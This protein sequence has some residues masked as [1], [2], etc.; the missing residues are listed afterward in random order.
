MPDPPKPPQSATGRPN[1]R[2][3]RSVKRPGDRERS[4]KSFEMACR[5]I[6]RQAI[7]NSATCGPDGGPVT[8]GAF[9]LLV[10]NSESPAN[11]FLDASARIPPGKIGARFVERVAL[12]GKI[13]EALGEQ[14]GGQIAVPHPCGHWWAFLSTGEMSRFCCTTCDLKIALV[15][16]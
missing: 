12:S 2:A 8:T 14:I 1:R 3:R 4:F 10:M 6:V 13:V 16:S 5:G 9:V 11:K 7:N 15:A